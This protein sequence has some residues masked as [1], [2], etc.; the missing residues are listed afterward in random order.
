VIW[1]FDPIILG[2]GLTVEN[3]LSRL[4]NLAEAISPFT[5]KLV[6]SFVDWYR[7]TARELGNLNPKFR[8]PSSEEMYTLAQGIVTINNK[9][10]S[11][12]KIATCAETLDLSSL[13]IEHNRCVD[14]E[15]LH[16][17][18]PDCAEFERWRGKKH[19]DRQLSL[20]STLST[21]AKNRQ[22]IEEKDSNQR[23]GCGCAPSKDIGSY[24]TCRHF[25]AYCYANTSPKS[26]LTRLSSMSADDEK[27]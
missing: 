20:L 21:T 6:F 12:L 19:E 11:P 22:K 4:R 2:G 27:L 7:K 17:L 14:P 18:C 10:P 16:R 9:L 5:E 24:N 15:L 8:S 25:C 1:R 13:G 23:S 26:V 3:T